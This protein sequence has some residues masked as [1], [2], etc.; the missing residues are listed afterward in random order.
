MRAA[1]RTEKPT[2]HVSGA[3]FQTKDF[4][5]EQ[6]ISQLDQQVCSALQTV[7]GILL[8]HLQSFCH[9]LHG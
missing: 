9:G 5:V 4:L 6:S 1:T 3:R 8:R 2:K 7:N